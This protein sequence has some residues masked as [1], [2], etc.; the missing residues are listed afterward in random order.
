[1]LSLCAARVTVEFLLGIEFYVVILKSFCWLWQVPSGT[2]E[3][4]RSQRREE[5]KKEKKEKK[6]QKKKKVW[7]VF[8][9]FD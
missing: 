6:K 5:K 1:M 7:R 3:K 4:T 9:F 8:I 2:V